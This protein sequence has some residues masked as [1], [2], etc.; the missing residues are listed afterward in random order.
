[1]ASKPCCS[2]SGKKHTGGYRGFVQPYVLNKLPLQGPRGFQ[3]DDGDVG[4][5]G[6]QGSIGRTG[7]VGKK[8]SVG[9]QGEFG[10]VGFDGE[11]GA[12]GATGVEGLNGGFVEGFPSTAMIFRVGS[13]NGQ[14]GSNLIYPNFQLIES[15]L[16]TKGAPCGNASTSVWNNSGNL[17][18]MAV[19]N[20][21]F[22][23]SQPAGF[24][25]TMNIKNYYL[26]TYNLT[27]FLTDDPISKVFFFE[28]RNL[29]TGLA[30]P[31]SRS[32]VSV[33]DLKKHVSHTFLANVAVGSQIGLFV[34]HEEIGEGGDNICLQILN[35]NFIIM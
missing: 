28:C 15:K 18:N 22:G 30:Y 31:G 7:R 16:A 32:S 3:G 9:G 2:S 4:L 5:I 8:G 20:S 17:I 25:V 10:D 19:F 6:Y 33:N 14:F 12:T 26:I 27:I 13:T 34:S 11:I 35:S 24:L 21:Q 23:A 29:V 1:M